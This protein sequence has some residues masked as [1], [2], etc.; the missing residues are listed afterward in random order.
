MFRFA[1]AIFEP[2]MCRNCVHDVQITVAEDGGMDR[3]GSYYESAGALRDMVQNHLLQLLCL[4][5]MEPPLRLEGESIRDE[6]VK[7]LRAI[8][9]LAPE[10]VV[11]QCVRGQYAAAGGLVGYRQEGGVGRDSQ[12]ETYAAV[13]LEVRNRR[14][15]GVPFY[16]RT[17][18]RLARRVGEIVV[19]FVREPAPIFGGASCQWRL[20]NRLIFRLQP[21]QGISIAFDAKAP[22]PRMLLRPVRMD[23][24][25]EKSFEMASPEA[26]ERL[27]LDA[28]R[29]QRSL[30][31]RDDEVEASWK[32]ADSI[33]A[34]WDAA[35]P[36]PLLPYK[37]ATWGPDAAAGIF[38]DAETSWQT[39]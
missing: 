8:G 11:G 29:G 1:N 30:F 25:Y 35:Q 39:A 17:G 3:R 15:A 31:A 12:V 38:A 9:A 36:P 13:R 14:W 33:R 10:Q 34:V 7:V 22:G 28:L 6:K 19:T 24:D 20:P 18:K 32:I 23:F 5:A 21:E 4:V 27:L 37:C 16:L 2:I 26:Y